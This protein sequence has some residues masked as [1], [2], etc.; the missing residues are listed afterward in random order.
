MTTGTLYIRLATAADRDT[1]V[2]L[3]RAISPD[4]YIPEVYDDWIQDASPGGFFVVELDGRIIACYA[5]EFPRPGQAYLEAMRVHPE[6]QGRGIGSDICRMQVEQAYTL[7][8]QDIYLLSALQNHPAH[9]IVEKN[10]FRKG[11]AWL[12]YDELEA[13]PSLPVGRARLARPGEAPRKADGVIASRQIGWVVMRA[14]AA[15]WDQGETAVVSGPGG[16]EGLML[17]TPN[18]DGLLIRRLEGSPEAAADL[19]GFAVRQMRERALPRLAI[20]LPLSAEPLL[21]P[22]QLDPTQGFRAYVFHHEGR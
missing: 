1:V 10:G 11:E 12:V 21:A 19:L 14:S 5:V 22:L 3:S 16:L 6:T 9:R 13:L 20:S 8:A 15:D 4:D 18:D 2:A 17:Y 7:G